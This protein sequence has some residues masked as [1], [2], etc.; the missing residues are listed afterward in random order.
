MKLYRCPKCGKEKD[1]KKFYLRKGTGRVTSYCKSCNTTDRRERARNFKKK[2]ITYLGGYCL[3]CGYNKSNAALDFHHKDP[4]EKDFSIGRTRT[5]KLSKRVK[6]E[7]D[8]CILI[9]SN[10]HRE[11]HEK[12]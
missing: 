5:M 6:E 9:C 11:I 1:I 10:C 4:S 2:C 3:I 8:K 12:E 7:L